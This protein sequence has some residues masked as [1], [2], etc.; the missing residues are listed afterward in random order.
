VA[1]CKNGSPKRKPASW[2]HFDVDQRISAASKI[3]GML[4]ENVFSHK[5]VS[6]RAKRAAYTAIV[7][8]TLLYGSETWT[9]SAKALQKLRSFHNRCARAMVHI[10]MWHTREHHIRTEDVL[11][12]LELESLDT[13]L[14]RRVARWLGHVAR[15]PFDRLP[16]KF[17]SAW[18]P[19]PRPRSTPRLHFGTHM[20]N[21][22][23]RINVAPD[24][25][26]AKAQDKDKWRETVNTFHL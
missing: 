7:L 5:K 14:L 26:Y 24:K 3:F 17:L 10:S 11:R 19:L 6:Y 22:L 18:I 25:W 1:L 16:R 8:S 4:R 21:T 23:K 12:R 13:Y 2:L 20:R 9:L 15:L